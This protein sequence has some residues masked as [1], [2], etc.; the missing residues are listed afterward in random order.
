LNCY[1]LIKL[2]IAFCFGVTRCGHVHAMGTSSTSSALGIDFQLNGQDQL[3]GF[4]FANLAGS[5]RPSPLPL[6]LF[7]RNPACLSYAG[8]TSTFFPVYSVGSVQNKRTFLG[9]YPPLQ[10]TVMM[11][12]ASTSGF[13]SSGE[14]R[15]SNV[16]PYKSV[17]SRADITC[18]QEQQ[19]ISAN[20]I[21]TIS[22]S[23]TSSL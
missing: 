15:W 13:G 20:T 7:A 3:N 6:Y 21:I 23:N 18:S 8:T 5:H 19:V 9:N 11:L 2:V 16:T 17:Q 1:E 12:I 10:Y 14:T 4:H 22:F